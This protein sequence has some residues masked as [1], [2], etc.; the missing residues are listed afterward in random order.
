MNPVLKQIL[1]I[2]AKNALNA[3]LVTIPPAYHFHHLN[4]AGLEHILWVFASAVVARE[5]VIWGPKLMTWSSSPTPP[6]PPASPTS[7]TRA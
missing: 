6:G 2:S 7:E 3:V 1:I 5:V 4:R